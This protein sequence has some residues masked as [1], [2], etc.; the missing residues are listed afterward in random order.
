M[1]TAHQV[2]HAY[3]QGIFPMADPDENNEIFWY[4][5]TMRGV[6]FPGEFHVS[7]NLRRL[8]AKKTFELRMDGDFEACIRGCAARPETWISEEIIEVYTGLHQMGYAH[9]F[10]AWQDGKMAGGLYGVALGKVFFGESMFHKVTDASKAAL[11]FLVEWMKKE[12][13]ELLDCQFINEHLLQFGAREI[14]QEEFLELLDQA[15]S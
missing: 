2:L 5:P 1:L 9:S 13:Y 11:V 15:L 6:I 14:K 7:K 8:I 4:E 3:T 12:G 10:E